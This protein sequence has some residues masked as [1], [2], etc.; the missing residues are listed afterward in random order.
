MTAVNDRP[1]VENSD[2]AKFALRIMRAMARRAGGDVDLLP[3]LRDVAAEVD[4]ALADAVAACRRDGYS[5]AEIAERLGITRQAAHKRFG[6]HV[7]QCSVRCQP[8]VDAK[9]PGA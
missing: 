9:R 6:P 5:W 2:Y 1:V 7:E 3:A 4:R 8:R